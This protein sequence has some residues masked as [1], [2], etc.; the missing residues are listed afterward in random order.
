MGVVLI[1]A[2]TIGDSSSSSLPSRRET[3]EN[4]KPPDNFFFQLSFCVSGFINGV[5]EKKK[6]N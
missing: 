1:A 4:L 6:V 2:K 3:T 5:L